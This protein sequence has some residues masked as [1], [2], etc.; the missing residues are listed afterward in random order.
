MEQLGPAQ[1]LSDYQG[2]NTALMARGRIRFARGLVDEAAADLLELGRRCESWTLR[3]PAAFPWRSQAAIAL[4]STGPERARD[5]ADEE[6]ELARSFGAG[7]ALGISL[8]AA[9]LVRGGGDGL[10][11]LEEATE[12]LAASPARLEH[13]RALVDLGAAQRRSGTGKRPA[14]ASRRGSTARSSAA[15]CH[16]RSSH[17]PS[18]RSRERARGA[19]GSRGATH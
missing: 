2:N 6:I 18:W 17:A 10:A 13:A 8:R 12:V 15:R 9:G 16:L 4:R 7:R 11:L 14:C 3:N 1:E 5:L 19:T